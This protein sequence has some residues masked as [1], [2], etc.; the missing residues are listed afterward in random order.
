MTEVQSLLKSANETINQ[1]N[2]S[3]NDTLNSSI[4]YSSLEYSDDEKVEEKI[5]IKK[6][7]WAQVKRTKRAVIKKE[8]GW[9]GGLWRMLLILFI[10]TIVVLLVLLFSG[11]DDGYGLGVFV[12][13][14]GGNY[15][16]W[17]KNA[18]AD[19]IIKLQNIDILA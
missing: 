4:R 17:C 16:N 1:S 2:K 18:S 12:K 14:Q 8:A 5:T 3:A 10:L 13:E 11:V 9:C 15:W 6:K 19:L 7:E